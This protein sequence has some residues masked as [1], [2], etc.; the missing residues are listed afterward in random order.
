MIDIDRPLAE[1]FWSKVKITPTCW[2]W[3]GN[4][5]PNG[6]GILG[7]T[8]V[9]GRRTKVGAHRIAYELLVGPIPE[10]LTIDHLC[11]VRHCVNPAHLEP[12]TQGE[13]TRRGG[14]AKRT[15]CL[16]GHPLDGEN[17]YIKP[18]GQRTCRACLRIAHRSYDQSRSAQLRAAFVTSYRHAD[19]YERDGYV[20]QLCGEPI[21]MLVRSPNPR[22][23]TIDHIIP[24]RRGGT[25]EP[26]NVQAA[27]RSCNSSK[28]RRL[29]GEKSG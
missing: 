7:I 6:Y 23:P 18:S 4:R 9:P 25:D 10:G 12:V 16:R 11:R 27:H 28:G 5:N 14:N 3:T 17:L 2:L 21:D 26:G 29:P 8:V 24:L 15:H 20:C 13:N 19:I 1:R 22:S